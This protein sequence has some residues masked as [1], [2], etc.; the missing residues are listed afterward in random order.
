MEFKKKYSFHERTIKSFNLLK[1]YPKRIPIIC[2][3][4]DKNLPTFKKTRFLVPRT[5]LMVEFLYML[6]K[7]INLPREMS[8]YLFINDNILPTSTT[9]SKAYEDYKDRDGFLYV[10]CFGENTF[11]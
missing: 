2:H 3:N 7:N 4:K 10:K 8:M 6:R 9:M 5:Y 1:K 11:G